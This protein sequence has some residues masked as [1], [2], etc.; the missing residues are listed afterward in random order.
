[1]LKDWTL[2]YLKNKDI[3]LKRISTIEDKGSYILVKN[4]DETHVIV[5]VK[6]KLDSV[7]PVLDDFKKYEALHKA[8]K[9]TLILYNTKKNM[10]LLLKSWDAFLE[11][12]TL[13]IIFANPAVNDKWIISPAVH[14]KI[15]D[16]KSLKQGLISMFQ[17]VEPF[18]G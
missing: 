5:I 16:K 9:L 15:A 18:Y 14:H 1:M 7:Q 17:N 11:F 2:N 8:Q 12:P 10:E 4:K 13:S 6:E 3:M